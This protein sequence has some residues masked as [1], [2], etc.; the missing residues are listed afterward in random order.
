MSSLRYHCFTNV[1]SRGDFI[2]WQYQNAVVPAARQYLLPSKRFANLGLDSNADIAT[3][4]KSL[5]DTIA[6]KRALWRLRSRCRR[7]T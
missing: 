5:Y 6:E 1:F 7:P 4:E 3:V 2:Q